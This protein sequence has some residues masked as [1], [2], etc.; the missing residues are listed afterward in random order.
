MAVAKVKLSRDDWAAAALDAIAE[1]DVGAVRVEVLA[2]RMGVSKGSFYWHYSDRAELVE[3]AVRLWEERT[4]EAVIR[5]LELIADSRERLRVLSRRAL[6]DARA[7]RVTSV[8]S[9]HSDDPR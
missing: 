4:T 2:A 7:W 8:L 1:G 5:D 3:A 6:G 9:G